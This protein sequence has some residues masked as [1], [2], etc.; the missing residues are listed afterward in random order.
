M[1]FK[2]KDTDILKI[3]NQENNNEKNKEWKVGTAELILDKINLKSITINRNSK[4]RYDN[5]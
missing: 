1:C 3:K 4:D 5:N 2:R